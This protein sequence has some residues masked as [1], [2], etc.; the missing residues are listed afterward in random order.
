M[1]ARAG[2]P[3]SQRLA[4]APDT[5]RLEQVVAQ[6]VPAALVPLSSPPPGP[7]PVAAPVET[8]LRERLIDTV[9]QLMVGHTPDAGPQA[10]MVLHDSVLPGT[11]VVVQQVAAQL[12]VSFE[13]SAQASRQRLERAAPAFAQ[14]L[15]RRLGRDVEVLL[16]DEN[17]HALEPVHG[18]ANTGEVLQ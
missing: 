4:D 10:R 18:R 8:A 5:Q 2:K 16:H 14:A 12:Q 13:C 6:L 7:P 9:Q 3:A 11:T 1:H 17:G 15:A